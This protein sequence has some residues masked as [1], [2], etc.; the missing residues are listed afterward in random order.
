[1]DTVTLKSKREA[2]LTQRELVRRQQ[3]L[4]D[5]NEIIRDLMLDNKAKHEQLKRLEEL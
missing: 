4:A 1:M 5:N 3:E 2:K